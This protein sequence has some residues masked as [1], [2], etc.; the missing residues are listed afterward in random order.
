MTIH[1]P[2]LEEET[3]TKWTDDRVRWHGEELEDDAGA[4]EEQAYMDPFRD[5]NPF[6]MFRFEF[7]VRC[8]DDDDGTTTTA[9]ST[10]TI[11]I[12]LRGYKTDADEIWKSTGLT[13]WKAAETLGH[14]MAKNSKLFRNQTVLELGAGLGLCGI[15]AHRLGTSKTCITDGDSDALPLLK[16]NLERN[17]RQS[18]ENDNDNLPSTASVHQL[19]WGKE[20]TQAFA[21]RHHQTFPVILASD[22]IYARCIV[23][24]LW[25]TVSTL[26]EKTKSAKFIMAYFSKRKVN[27]TI[28]VVLEYAQ[29]TGFDYEL[30]EQDADG[31]HVYIFQWKEVV[32]EEE[33]FV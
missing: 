20:T 6:E 25:D 9:T 15:L 5:Q 19:I 22:I 11:P 4:E 16:E 21:K 14:Y 33:T 1:R 3:I 31:V 10:T 32:E 8:D 12:E 26:L 18:N 24:P 30:V 13:I 23:E 28:D 27:V 7:N 2:S 29:Q 17:N